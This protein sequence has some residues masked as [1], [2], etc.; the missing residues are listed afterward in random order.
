VGTGSVS[1]T[2]LVRDPYPEGGDLA[3]NNVLQG[4]ST[5]QV[6]F[7]NTGSLDMGGCSEFIFKNNGLKRLLVEVRYATTIDPETL[8]QFNAS[9]RN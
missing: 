8:K 7:G 1:I 9:S 5:E 6:S 2:W 4:G 3:I